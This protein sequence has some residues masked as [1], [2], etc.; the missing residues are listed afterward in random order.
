MAIVVIG[1]LLGDF[2]GIIASVMRNQSSIIVAT[3][4]PR[5]PVLRTTTVLPEEGN[6]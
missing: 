5:V 6:A 4:V 2:V 3:V 1:K